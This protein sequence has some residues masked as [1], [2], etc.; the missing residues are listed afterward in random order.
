MTTVYYKLPPELIFR[1]ILKSNDSQTVQIKGLDFIVHPH[2][3]PSDK[4]R[5]TNFLLESIQPIVSGAHLCDMGCGIGV[6]GIYAL[7]QGAKSIVQAD[8]NPLAVKNA[9]AN[10]KI[11]HFSKE[12][13]IYESDCFGEIPKQQFDVIV[14]NIPFQF[15]DF[16]F[17]N[18]KSN[19][20]CIFI[21]SR[22]YY[23]QS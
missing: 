22:W 5:T 12:I 11:H 15:S 3:Y 19:C 10:K 1:D 6:V 8:I 23:K 4:F 2:V 20:N 7:S 17:R 16:Q 21:N 9:K 13:K 18:K 14:F